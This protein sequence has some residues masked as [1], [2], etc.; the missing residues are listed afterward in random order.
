[1]LLAAHRRGATPTH[2]YED[3]NTQPLYEGEL[4]SQMQ[5]IDPRLLLRS[6][7]RVYGG[8]TNCW[9]GWTRTLS[10]IDFERSDLDPT[11][12]WPI[13]AAEVHPYY[14]AALHDCSLG[15]FDPDDYDRPEAWVGRT[16]API[17]ALPEATGALRTGV[18]R[19][20]NGSG[21]ALDGA[22]D[23]QHV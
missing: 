11:S 8:T 3:P 2:R 1:V 9:G 15:D 18:F 5:Q 23:F 20:M 16:E 19:I 12:A 14:V 4:T 21:P 13:D 17:A 7:I 10:P 22:L 6:R